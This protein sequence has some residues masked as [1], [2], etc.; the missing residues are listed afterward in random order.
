M[1]YI[2][3][4]RTPHLYYSESISK[5][6]RV[7]KD[8]NNFHNKEIVASIKMDGENFS[9]YDDYCHARSI[10]S[11]NHP[12]RDYVKGLWYSKCYNLDYDIR[13][14]CENLYAKHQIH[15]HNLKSYLYLISVW[16]KD[17]CLQKNI[18]LN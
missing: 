6:D 11:N 5:D 4:P 15:Y 12:S 17:L 14:C 7:L 2:K 1:K 13:I 9:G 10:D 3:Y 8:D 18:Q 16:R